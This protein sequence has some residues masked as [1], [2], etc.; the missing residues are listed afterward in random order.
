MS[1]AKKNKV[2]LQELQDTLETNPH[3]ETVYFTAAGEHYFTAHELL[4]KGKGT[5]KFYGYLKVQPVLHKTVGERRIY[6]Q[7]SVATPNTFISKEMTRD[8]VLAY[9]FAGKEEAVIPEGQPSYQE[10]LDELK[11]L[12]KAQAKGKEKKEEQVTA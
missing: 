4:N 5:G 2:Q 1:I 10:L 6:K 12:K 9:K 8:E 7:Q 3:I 11:A